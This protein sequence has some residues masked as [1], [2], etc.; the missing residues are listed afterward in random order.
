MAVRISI[1]L[2]LW[3]DLQSELWKALQRA[4]DREIRRM[5]REEGA[6]I[7][8]Y[9]IQLY[10]GMKMEIYA[11]E[12]PPPHFHIKTDHGGASYRITDCKR[13]AGDLDVSSRVL[14]K[15]WRQNRVAIVELWNSTRPS[16][17]QVG[18][19]EMPIGW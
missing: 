10:R 2:K 14:K 11:D 8:P 17:C 18:P 3:P 13:I 6:I 4:S 9:L 15:W 5:E 19:M 7:R 16:D 12:H 1:P